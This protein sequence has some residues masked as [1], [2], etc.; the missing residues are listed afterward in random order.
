VSRARRDE[1]G[2]TM[3]EAAFVIPILFLFIFALIDIGLW[4][5]ETSQASSAARDGARTGIVLQLN[6]STGAAKTA[7]EKLIRDSVVARLADN[8][9]TNPANDITITCLTSAS[10]D[11]NVA[12]EDVASGSGR[13][14]VTVKWKRPFLTFVGGIFGG[15]DRTVTGKAT[16]VVVGRPSAG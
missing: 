1:R 10:S 16:M 15:A 13:I 11:T 14:R 8:R 6:G 4:V 7:N 5:F 12:C 9:I 2:V 3:V